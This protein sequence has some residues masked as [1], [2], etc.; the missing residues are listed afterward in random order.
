MA[1]RLAKS[2]KKQTA[3][4]DPLDMLAQWAGETFTIPA[5]ISK[6]KPFRLHKFQRDFLRA[7][8]S[9]DPD[10]PT[11]RTLIYST[12][13]KL[14]KSTLLGLLLLA[15]MC[16]DS[17][18]YVPGFVGAVAAP[19][20][21]HAG[22]IA[23]A[24][25]ALLETAGR[26][27]ELTRRAD[28]RPGKLE[29]A[30]CVCFL[31]T[32]SIKQGHGLDLDLA[33]IDECGLIEKN[34][35]ELITAF[36]DA[37]ATKDGQLILTGTRGDSPSYND[38]ID[39]PDKRTHVTLYAADKTDDPGDPQIWAKANPALGEIKSARFMEDAFAKAQ[40]SGSTTEFEVWHL[41]KPLSPTRQLLLDYATLA[42][43]YRPAPL[44][45][46]GEPVHL[47]IDLGGSAS[48]TAAVLAY[49][50]SGL[51]RLLGAFPGADMDLITR[52]KR[53]QVG[54]LWQRAALDGDLIETSGSVSDLQEFLP[55][56]VGL[57]GNHPIASVSCD[58]YRQ[59]E[60]STALAR[61]QLAWPVIY[62][63]TGPRDG[64]ADIRATRRLFIAGAVQMKRSA[65]LEGSLGEADV[66]VSTTGACQLDKSHN[67][68]RI[69]V[70][71]A[72]VLACSAVVR[73]KDTPPT[74]YSVEVI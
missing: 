5:G 58:R 16:P 52:G 65:L 54:D 24:M 7:Y 1:L 51:I 36:F 15:H 49:Q 31:S 41:N 32:G 17:P 10:G 9:R 39:N 25:L 20:E 53:D 73:A 69:D 11:Y 43:S 63:G 57:L 74:E 46:P 71:S 48:M 38:L 64:D 19:T 56:V 21:K 28:P 2:K 3:S 33:L 30:D 68:A 60:F 8:L 61:R 42:K 29:L 67:T 18:L 66:R 6:G 47:G 50:D 27:K 55:A 72:L 22:Y 62:R 59:H 26:E 70:V 35:G 37:L 34:Q 14:G 40:A 23:Q 44:P 12:P 45:I 4:A 13:R